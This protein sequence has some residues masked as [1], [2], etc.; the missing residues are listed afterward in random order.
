M[1]LPLV[2]NGKLP[3]ILRRCRDIPLERSKITNLA[4]PLVFNSP[5]GGVPLGRSP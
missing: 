5:D 3:A 1:R 2:I 4:T